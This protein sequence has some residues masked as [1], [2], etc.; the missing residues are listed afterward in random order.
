MPLLVLVSGCVLVPL[1]ALVG[2]R[3]RDLVGP[4]WRVCPRVLLGLV[5]GCVLAPFLVVAGWCV[6]VSFLVRA[7]FGRGLGVCPRVL[8][9]RGWGVCPRAPFGLGRGVCRRVLFGPAWEGVSSWPL[10]V[11]VGGCVLVSFLVLGDGLS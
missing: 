3:S 4:G 9:G 11:L 1:L 10:L 8:F 6:L 2:G 7:L 5:G